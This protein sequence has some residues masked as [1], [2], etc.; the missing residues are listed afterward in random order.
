MILS[1]G[2]LIYADQS[3]TNEELKAFTERLF[4]QLL[5][6]LEIVKIISKLLNISA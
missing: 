6:I 2:V 3:L 1:S 4:D 5:G